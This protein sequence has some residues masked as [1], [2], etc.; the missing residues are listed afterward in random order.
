[1]TILELVEK[2]LRDG[3]YDGLVS[4]DREC[5]CALDDLGPCESW[6][7]AC[8]PAHK[9]DIGLDEWVMVPGK[10]TESEDPE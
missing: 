9:R 6:I 8:E 5:G 7:G 1:M 4:E 2:Y 10:R 3:G